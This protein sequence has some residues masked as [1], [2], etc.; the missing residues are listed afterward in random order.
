MTARTPTRILE[1]GRG[2]AVFLRLLLLL[3]MDAKPLRTD[4]VKPA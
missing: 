1:R 2:G 3:Q 4:C